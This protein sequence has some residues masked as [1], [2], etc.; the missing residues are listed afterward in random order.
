MRLPKELLRTSAVALLTLGFLGLILTGCSD[1]PPP[2]SSSGIS[3]YE[4]PWNPQPGDQING[5]AIPL[6]NE[7]YWENQYGNQ[8]N[9]W[10]AVP[11]P[12]PI[13]TAGGV[14]TLGLHSLIIPAGAV[15]EPVN[16]TLTY[17]SSTAI[18]VDC[19]PSPFEFHVPVTLILSYSGTQYANTVIDPADLRIYYMPPNWDGR[20]DDLVEMP[21]V[22]DTRALTVTCQTDHFS[23]Y[24]IG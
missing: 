19:G 20:S 17:A 9:P 21:S 8:I 23:R 7:D 14:I 5:H 12:I 16:I 11:R 15:D 24:I 22:V 2:T 6:V 18:A 1:Y 13:G 3:N 10:L 4:S